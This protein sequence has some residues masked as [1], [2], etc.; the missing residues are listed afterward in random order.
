MS[1][2]TLSRG[3]QTPV[4]GSIH[5]LSGPLTASGE[6]D[7][8]PPDRPRAPRTS[9]LELLELVDLARTI[10]PETNHGPAALVE[11]LR[12]ALAADEVGV[13]GFEHRADGVGIEY[14]HGTRGLSVARERIEA[15]L[16]QGFQR[17]S[18][19]DPRAPEEA[20]Q[21]VPLTFR[22]LAA[23]RSARA[24]GV[25]Q[26]LAS[27]GLGAHDVLR[28]LVCARG[29]L[30]LWI[31]AFRREPFG[32]RERSVLGQVVAALRDRAAVERRLRDG[33]LA[34]AGLSA[35]LD[36][37]PGAAFVVRPGGVIVHANGAGRDL[38]ERDPSVRRSLVEGGEYRFALTRLVVAGVP[39]HWLAVERSG[40]ASLPARLETAAARWTLTPR[41]T[42]V[43]ALVA[44]GACNKDV[45]AALGCA[46][47]TVERHLTSLLEK[48]RCEHR[49]GIVAR[50]WTE[51]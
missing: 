24:E 36:A 48:S 34:T 37:V 33:G 28:A 20:Q 11:P 4:P 22:D 1:A 38:L 8:G 16:A 49:A 10:D 31:G 35:A 19:F 5:G 44:R 2:D 12:A 13:I 6:L 32:P 27:L 25:R 15:L 39:P 46:E 21:N 51:P 40:S 14:L 50:F 26:V 9:R 42:Q 18:F 43:L 30:L 29:E 7:D 3:V 41:E 47:S 23:H 17:S 45:A